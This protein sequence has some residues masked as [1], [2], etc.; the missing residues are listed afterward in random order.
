MAIVREGSTASVARFRNVT[1]T[2]LESKKR[3]VAIRHLL[4]I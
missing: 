4:A 1:R 3:P 2:A